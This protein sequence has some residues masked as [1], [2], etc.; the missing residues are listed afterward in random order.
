MSEDGVF[1]LPQ[2]PETPI[3][4]SGHE[5][6]ATVRSPVM[7][8]RLVSSTPCL[9]PQPVSFDLSGI[10]DTETSGKDTDS[11]A[12]GRPNVGTRSCLTLY[13]QKIEEGGRMLPS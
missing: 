3:A 13:Q 10:S 1:H 9:V 8:P 12:E 7:R 4:G 6:N 5:H 2:V 11:E